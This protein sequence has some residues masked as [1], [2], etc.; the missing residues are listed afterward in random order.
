MGTGS[1]A[2]T[3]AVGPACTEQPLAGGGQPQREGQPRIPA[4]PAT[5]LRA[6]RLEGSHKDLRYAKPANTQ[7]VP[8]HLIHR[9]GGKDLLQ[10]PAAAPL[11]VV[12]VVAAAGEGAFV[13]RS[14]QGLPA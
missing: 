11:P 12:L 7:S 4:Q 8:P 13:A 3:K 5:Q 9:H 1:T 6:G 2:C 10:A 14:S